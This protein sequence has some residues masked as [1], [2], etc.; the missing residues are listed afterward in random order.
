MAVQTGWYAAFLP[1]FAKSAAFSGNAA[2]IQRPLERGLHYERSLVLAWREATVRNRL[3]LEK[4][5]AAL[6]GRIAKQ[7]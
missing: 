5:I 7:L 3:F 6:K 2:L 4:I 1:E